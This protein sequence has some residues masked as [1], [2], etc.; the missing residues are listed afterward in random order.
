M[1]R[2]SALEVENGWGTEEGESFCQPYEKQRTDRVLTPF[3]PQKT[4][5][6]VPVGWVF[7]L[8]SCPLCSI[9]SDPLM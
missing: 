7:V 2:L 4:T 3:R 9:R 5:G 8:A 1:V 6:L